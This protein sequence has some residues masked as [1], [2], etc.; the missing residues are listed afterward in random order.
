[1]AFGWGAPVPEVLTSAREECA[2]VG[3]QGRSLGGGRPQPE[4]QASSWWPLPSTLPPRSTWPSEGKEGG[5]HLPEKVGQ[6]GSLGSL[7]TGWGWVRAM[8]DK[9]SREIPWRG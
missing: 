1:M 4:A 2:G 3:G 9:P 5:A 8:S 7:D 6:R